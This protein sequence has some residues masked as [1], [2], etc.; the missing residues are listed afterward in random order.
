MADFCGF[1]R[2]G[3][4]LIPFLKNPRELISFFGFSS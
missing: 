3:I 4:I 1:Y 2:Q